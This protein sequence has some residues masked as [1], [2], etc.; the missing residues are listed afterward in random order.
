M[1]RASIEPGSDYSKSFQRLRPMIVD[2]KGIQYVDFI[3]TLSPRYGRLFLDIA[4]GYAALLLTCAFVVALP[5]DSVIPGWLGAGLGALSVGFWIAYLQ[6]FIHEGAHFN[7]DPDRSRSDELCNLLIAW[8]IGTSVQKY[9]IIHFQHHRALGGVED[10]EM[11][12]FFPLNLLFIIK[13]LL[14]IRV[15][16][17]L[18]SRKTLQAKKETIR[19]GNGEYVGLAGLAAHIVILAATYFFGS[20]WLSLAWIA[21]VG[22]IFPFFGALRQLLE[23]RDERAD[24]RANYFETAHGAY[25]R[26]FGSDVFSSIFGGAGFNRHLL[27]HWEPSISYTNLPELEAYLLD[28]DVARLIEMRRSSYFKTF[29]SLFRFG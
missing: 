8:M 28:T 19:D 7:F 27:H 12:Y 20:V 9:R 13:G 26:M 25:T 17:V 2:S 29:A 18:T 4:L 22:A 5:A 10:S 24:S 6:L 23:H 15:L 14:G 3:K 21:G 16:E 1:N 11:T